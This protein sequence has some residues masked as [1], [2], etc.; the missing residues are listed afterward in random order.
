MNKTLRVANFI[1]QYFNQH[2]QQITYR[3]LGN[4][5]YIVAGN[6]YLKYHQTLFNEL[7]YREGLGYQIDTVV[8]NFGDN[9]QLPVHSTATNVHL[10]K[11][12]QTYLIKQLET[13]TDLSYNKIVCYCAKIN[14][15]LHDSNLK[16]NIFEKEKA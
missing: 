11:N 7:F 2:N 13:I 1:V 12:N 4:I 5:L 3:T 10:S 15:R 14:Q 16:L 9:K 6:Y 8:T